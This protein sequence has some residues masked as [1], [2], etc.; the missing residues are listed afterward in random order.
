VIVDAAGTDELCCFGVHVETKAGLTG[1]INS[2]A[3]LS[4]LTGVP[5]VDP[6]ARQV[7]VTPGGETSE[8]VDEWGI[9]TE[10]NWDL[11]AN[12][13]TWIGSYRDWGTARDQ[14]IDFSGMDRAYRDDF[15]LDFKTHT[16]EVRFNGQAGKVNWLVGAFYAGEKIG[17]TDT[18]RFGKD[19]A[20]YTDLNASG[21]SLTMAQAGLGSTNPCT[22]TTDYIRA[23]STVYGSLGSGAGSIYQQIVCPGLYQSVYNA[24]LPQ[25]G[26]NTALADSIARSTAL[27]VSTTYGNQIAATAPKDGDGQN[28]DFSSTHTQ[29]FAFFTHNEIAVSERLNLTVGLRYSAE[30]KDLYANLN[31]TGSGCNALQNT[32]LI[33]GVASANTLS[34][35]FENSALGGFNLLVC[36]PVVNTRANGIYNDKHEE[37][38]W[39][40]TLSARFN[41][42]DERMVYATLALG[43][44]GGGYNMDRSAFTVT[45]TQTTAV[46]IKD[47]LFNAEFNNNLELGWK[48]SGLPG[49][50][51]LNGAIFNQTITD[52]QV[53]GFTG[54]NFFAFNVPHVISRG[55]ELDMIARPVSGLTLNAGL[56]YNEAF[57]DGKT[58]VRNITFNDGQVL[59]GAPKWT[60]TGGL[61][62]RGLITPKLGYMVYVDSRYVSEYITQLVNE[63]DSGSTRQRPYTLTNFRLGIGAP[64]R[65]WGFE[66]WVRNLT[67]EFYYG[68]ALGVPEQTGNY[69]VYPG[70]PRSM[71]ITLRARF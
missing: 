9:S 41:L 68:A 40:G 14:D 18:I 2:I 6:E 48:F 62:Y 50:T 33:G 59:S 27:S 7:A 63:A 11:G 22:G 60:V 36:N 69:A 70:E 15:L 66:F 54:F 31:A 38:A 46:N 51:T 26:G 1:G 55:V 61:T 19:G 49:R 23:G 30:T 35:S 64:D 4:G 24:T 57:V 42:S 39:S 52:F 5:T 67:D 8:I 47:W 29:S 65:N 34:K 17:Y 43:Y 45:P 56:L 25:V 3:G 13:L 20:R 71:G 16:Q 10:L 28:N 32:T 12:K 21:V 37:D 58:K 44:K 53:T